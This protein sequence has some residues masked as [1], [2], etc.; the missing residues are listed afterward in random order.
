MGGAVSDIKHQEANSA[1]VQDNGY[2]QA[3]QR[4]CVGEADLV[5][6]AR[7]ST[8]PRASV[9]RMQAPRRGPT[10]HLQRRH[11]HGG[12]LHTAVTGITSVCVIVGCPAT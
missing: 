5:L 12:T 11:L 10:L 7:L 1:D 8:A 9:H 6:H 4:A 3:G 2:W